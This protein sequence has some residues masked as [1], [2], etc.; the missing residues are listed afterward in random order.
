[1]NTNTLGTPAAAIEATI[2]KF[3]TAADS[4]KAEML[5]PL[6]HPAFRVMFCMQAGTTP[7]QLDRQQFLQMVK[8]GKIGGKPRTTVVASISIANGFASAKARMLREDSAFHGIYSLVEQGG[9]WQLLEE[10]VLMVP[11]P[12]ADTATPKTVTA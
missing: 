5:E 9:Q 12:Q 7:T 10:A 2:T 6:L 3:A 4:Q 8:D 11:I 1:M